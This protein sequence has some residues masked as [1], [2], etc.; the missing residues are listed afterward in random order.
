[1]TVTSEQIWGLLRA[2]LALIGGILIAKGYVDA[3]LWE[4]IIGGIGALFVAGWSLWSNRYGT[5]NK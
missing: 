3:A 2:F 4:T 5:V 1:M